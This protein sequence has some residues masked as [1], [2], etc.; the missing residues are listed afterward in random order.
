MV[1]T[2]TE[3]TLVAMLL[4]LVACEPR[5]G[6]PAPQ[7][8][9]VMNTLSIEVVSRPSGKRVSLIVDAIDQYGNHGTNADTG[10]PYPWDAGR[11]TPYKHR[12]FY[13]LGLIVSVRFRA[14]MGGDPGD[15]LGCNV[16]DRGVPITGANSVVEIPAQRL[17][18][19]VVCL[20]T[21]AP[22]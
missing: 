15:L 14:I 9:P 11:N 17:S 3:L 18:A 4:T 13:E 10:R 22:A 2:M 21:T 16:T 7:D 5:S 1:H 19:E 8:M 6:K 20:Y 12:I